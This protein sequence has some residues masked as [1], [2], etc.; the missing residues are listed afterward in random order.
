MAGCP[1]CFSRA[2]LFV[3][4]PT[5]LHAICSFPGLVR[6]AVHSRF[7]VL[8]LVL[9]PGVRGLCVLQVQDVGRLVSGQSSRVDRLL[10]RHPGGVVGCD[11]VNRWRSC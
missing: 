3:R 6:S 7:P 5:D 8:R 9:V 11:V 4:L 2:V 10:R 1:L